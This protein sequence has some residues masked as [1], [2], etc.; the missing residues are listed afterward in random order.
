MTILLAII[1]ILAILVVLVQLYTIVVGAYKL[2][3]TKG[4]FAMASEYMGW[5]L[6]VCILVVSFLAP[7]I[8][9]CLAAYVAYLCGI[10]IF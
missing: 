8:V 6:V 3:T 7:I 10:R 5:K 4:W 2:I 9:G 1:F